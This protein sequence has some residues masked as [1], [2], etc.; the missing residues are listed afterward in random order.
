FNRLA[1]AVAAYP[2]AVGIGL[3][4]DTGIIVTEGHHLQAIGAGTVVI[5]D[6]RNIDYN[7]IADISFGSPISVENIIVH[8]MSA[9]DIYNLTDRKFE[10]RELI[11]SVED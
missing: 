8:M 6:G 5:I 10:G 1:Q 4:E 9:G 11:S 3:G 7:N 2:G